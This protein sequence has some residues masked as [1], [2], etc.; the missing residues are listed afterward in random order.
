MRRSSWFAVVVLVGAACAPHIEPLVTPGA[1]AVLLT[2]G[3][4]A[5]FARTSEGVIAIDLG[6]SADSASFARALKPLD[7]APSDVRMVF[8]THSH[9]DHIGAWP[10]VRSARFFL[11]SS[12]VPLLLGDSAHGGWI[13]STADRLEPPHLPKRGDLSI[14]AFST[15]TVMMLG[16]DTL[17]VY[18]VPGHTAGATAY[19]FRGIL[20]LGDAITHSTIGGFGPAKRGF[21]ADR[22]A[23]I[24]SLGQL[25]SRLPEGRVRYACTAHGDC[26]PFSD[27]LKAF[28]PDTAGAGMPAAGPDNTLLKR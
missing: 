8:L 17:R 19:L 24:K 7:A 3:S 5:Y 14:T 27:V 23:A 25:W 16:A 4:M 13:P 28:R 18:L 12:E 11:A 1:S 22:A 20:F 9:R 6:W 15:D 2:R 21:T 26:G 10:L